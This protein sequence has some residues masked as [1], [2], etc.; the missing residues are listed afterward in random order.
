MVL[1]VTVFPC[2]CST[3]FC[4]AGSGSQVTQVVNE[5]L[6]VKEAANEVLQIIEHL[7][8]CEWSVCLCVLCGWARGLLV[9]AIQAELLIFR[10]FSNCSHHHALYC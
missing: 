3:F 7:H 10:H 9:H 4:L 2:S 5:F 8:A 6:I 1:V